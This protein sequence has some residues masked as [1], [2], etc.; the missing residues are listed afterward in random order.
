MQQQRVS[1]RLI[2]DLL[3]PWRRT[4]ISP[5]F[6]YLDGVVEVFGRPQETS[7]SISLFGRNGHNEEFL[8]K[9][10]NNRTIQRQFYYHHQHTCDQYRLLWRKWIMFNESYGEE[11]NSIFYKMLGQT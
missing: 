8:W 11:A 2:G 10:K 4:L 1:W 3:L 5:E 6:S 9:T 7:E